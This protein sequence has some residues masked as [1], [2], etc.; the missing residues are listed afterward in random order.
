[1]SMM[2]PEVICCGHA[3]YDLNFI[4]N[5]Y[6]QEDH[7]YKIDQLVQT[8]GGPASNAASLLSAWGAKA[9]Y[10]GLLGED[11]YGRLI[12]DELKTSGVNTSLV[13]T[14]PAKKTPLSAVIV[15]TSAGSRTVLNRREA[16][17]Q[18]AVTKQ[19][20]EILKQFHPSVLHFDGH[21]L[22][23]SLKMME[24]FLMRKQ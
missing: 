23:L 11:L 20:V 12:L 22:D 18:P 10:A 24:L 19:I 15:N 17:D 7:K 9:A 4:M 3:A 21:A 13:Q 1:M 6:P 2:K 5:E 8:G 16:R 14:D